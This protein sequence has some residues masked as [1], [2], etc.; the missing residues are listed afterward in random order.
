MTRKMFKRCV[1]KLRLFSFTDQPVFSISPS[2]SDFVSKTIILKCTVP[3]ITNQ[4]Q[5]KVESISWKRSNTEKGKQKTVGISDKD[6]AKYVVT[7]D[8]PGLK[9]INS[10]RTDRGKY[11]CHL[12]DRGEEM[13]ADINLG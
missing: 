5:F 6:Y 10:N 3:S 4:K 7:T 8:P 11:M 2:Y 9:I 1:I 13:I 12:S